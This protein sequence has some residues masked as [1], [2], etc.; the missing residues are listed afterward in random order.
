[1][2]LVLDAIVTILGLV[3]VA[4]YA[5]SLRGHFSSPEMPSG[6]K[7]ISLA[8]A[9]TTV[10][11]TWMVWTRQPP[12]AAVLTGLA[13]G[14]AAYGLFWWAIA[15]SR[16]ARLRFAFDPEGP[17]GLVTTGPYRYVRHPFYT[18]YLMFW[19]G[20]AIATGVAWSAVPV[21]VFALIYVLAARREEQLFSASGMAGDYARYK[22]RTG[23]LLPRLTPPRDATFS[24]GDRAEP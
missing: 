2:A 7:I 14:L 12:L 4:T 19:S 9:A 16:A 10:A 11:F 5:W 6:A 1:M 22:S 8:V 20:W 3:T 23:F 15:A 24:P 17:R 13:L 21:A 18:S